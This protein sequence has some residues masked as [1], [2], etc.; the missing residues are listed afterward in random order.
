MKLKT[1]KKASKNHYDEWLQ[2]KWTQDT[3]LKKVIWR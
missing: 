2:H 3:Y 1:G